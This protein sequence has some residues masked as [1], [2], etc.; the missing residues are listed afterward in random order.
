MLHMVLACSCRMN[1]EMICWCDSIY[2]HWVLRDCQFNLYSC[3]NPKSHQESFREFAINPTKLHR[4]TP[5]R[6]V[7]AKKEIHTNTIHWKLLGKRWMTHDLL[8]GFNM[9][10]E[11]FGD[12]SFVGL[13]P[14]QLLCGLKP[15]A[16][17]FALQLSWPP[18]ARE[19]LFMA[20]ES[21]ASI[22]G[23]IIIW[24]WSHYRWLTV[25]IVAG[26]SFFHGA[27]A[28]SSCH[29]VLHLWRGR[30]HHCHIDCT[31]RHQCSV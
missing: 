31:G 8:G 11:F 4:P 16:M 6:I 26:L 21:L 2:W 19:L 14:G 18:S 3:S 5:T 23:V 10:W 28:A 15:S 7:S 17:A 29:V 24:N 25:V 30:L 27:A 1:W 20:G 13:G 22:I 12:P 9:T